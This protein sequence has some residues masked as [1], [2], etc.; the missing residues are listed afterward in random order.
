MR[1]ANRR[2]RPGRRAVD[3]VSII[4]RLPCRLQAPHFLFC[5]VE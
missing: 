5:I 4:E 1:G 2:L 3:A